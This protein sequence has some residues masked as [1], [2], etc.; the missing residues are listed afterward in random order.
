MWP[1]N[2]YQHFTKHLKN[3]LIVAQEVAEDL[4]SPN[5]E[6]LHLL[7]ALSIE[8]GSIA[9]QAFLKHL[10]HPEAN[11][12]MIAILKE[13]AINQLDNPPVLS[14][15]AKTI[16]ERAVKIA[17]D[18][19][20][21]FIDSEHL[22]L[23]IISS[24][25]QQ[26]T[27][28]LTLTK[29]NLPE[30]TDQLN[31]MIKNTSKFSSINNS[32]ENQKI[33][34]GAVKNENFDEDETSALNFYGIDITSSEIQNKIDP[35][36]GRENDI[37]RLIEILSRRTKNNPILLGDPGTGKTAIVE[38][39]AK[40]ILLQQVPDVLIGKK[41][42][43]IDLAAMVAG[44]MYRGEFETRLKQV[45]E[46][47]KND[48]SA[49]LFIDEIHTVVGA[50]ASHGSLDA[51]NILKP[52]LAR[53]NLRLIGATTLDEYKKFIE[54]DPAFERRFQPIDIKEST[55]EDTIEIIKGIKNNYENFH[56]IKIS[57]EAITASVYLTN[58]YMPYRFFPDK[59]IDVI[60]QTCA[61]L[62]VALTKDGTQK[63]IH[64]T[65]LKLKAI[66][67]K[68]RQA[69]LN[70]TYDEAL[71]WR[72]NEEALI[73]KLS[74]LQDQKKNNEKKFLGTITRQD[75]AEVVSKI[76]KIPVTELL[77]EERHQ[78]INLEQQIKRAIIGQDEAI[79]QLAQTIR[80][81]KTGLSDPN[82]PI[83]T[84]MFLG[85]SGVGKTELAKQ[86]A[87]IVFKDPKAL[88]KIDMSELGES[89]QAS[90]L[91]GAP[92]GYVGYRDS[93]ML[94][95][96]VKRQ[97][98]SVVLLD[99][100]EKAHPDIF[101]LLLPI[102][103][104]GQISDAS[105]RSINFRNT[106]IIMT[107]NIGLDEF[108]QQATIGFQKADSEQN[109][110][111]FNV[112]KEKINKSLKDLFR[113][114]FLNRIDRVITFKPL[115]ASDLKK[116]AKLQLNELNKRLNIQGKK[117]KVN[118]NVYQHLA[119]TIDSNDQGARALRRVIQENIEAPLADL[120]INNNNSH[121]IN[122]E[123]KKDKI[124]VTAQ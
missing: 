59:A 48:P 80:R 83:G 84:F 67:E 104:E 120:L 26:L 27:R 79:N 8:K 122:I 85:P 21:S 15:E 86:L 2:I 13:Y 47:V 54:T 30:L 76:A 75:V 97:P 72:D 119:N 116:I 34:I 81:A 61:R 7:Y 12:L 64:E 95:D 94:A 36:I 111:D 44:T 90:K 56:H 28:C 77:T 118:V 14:E 51:A 103:E 123:T 33:K 40:R 115:N 11:Q 93:N 60:D 70:E 9:Q 99:E 53:G 65:E 66:G 121:E 89:F 91:L 112:L 108:N 107:S 39:L 124:V 18:A 82:R 96:T 49:I 113:P 78:L 17:F 62:K 3:I 106:I 69:I 32:A 101:N 20:H 58:R 43:T 105:G 23:A 63:L 71:T 38:G 100:I 24:N 52:E 4:H 117:I 1:E 31:L 6:P 19:R 50:G 68:K 110:N 109:E 114:E 16:I 92:A 25:N 22:L 88:I 55:S 35:V 29:I 46:E 74:A 42:I 102:F 98:Y 41:I 5:I 87:K 73:N 37:E 45:I 57:E 10:H